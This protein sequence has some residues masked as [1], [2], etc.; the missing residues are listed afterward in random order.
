MENGSAVPD[1]VKVD[2]KTGQTLVQFPDNIFSIDIKII[3]IDKDNTTREIDVTLDQSSI[4][5]D[6]SLKRSLENFIDRNYEES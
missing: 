2:P 5:P 1:W 3:A 4:K 6:K